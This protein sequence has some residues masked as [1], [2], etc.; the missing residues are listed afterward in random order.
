MDH[1][2]NIKSPSFLCF[3]HIG[4]CGRFSSK[5][6]SKWTVQEASLQGGAL[7]NIWSSNG[8][9]IFQVHVKYLGSVCRCLPCYLHCQPGSIH[10]SQEGI[11]WSEWPGWYQDIQSLQS[12]TTPQ[13][14][15]HPIQLLWGKQGSK[16]SF[17]GKGKA[18]MF[19]LNSQ[20]YICLVWII[21]QIL[22][23]QN[24]FQQL[25]CPNAR[26]LDPIRYIL[27]I[28]WTS[29]RN[30]IFPICNTRIYL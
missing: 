27:S 11:S 15:L 29:Y 17:F 13:I 9:K 18:R 21:F 4:W 12:T 26:V 3:E 5:L 14:H 19:Y 25:E 24:T 10:D 28:N 2:D 16:A 7:T 22:S 23:S 30:R 6:L 20:Y 8:K 1:R